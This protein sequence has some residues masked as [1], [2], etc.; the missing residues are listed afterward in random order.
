MGELLA[1]LLK[2]HCGPQVY[3]YVIINRYVFKHIYE[4]TCVQIA[5]GAALK[6]TADLRY[7]YYIHT[8]IYVYINS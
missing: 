4:A 3:T 1:V 7:I 6:D 2:G 5:R 8:Y